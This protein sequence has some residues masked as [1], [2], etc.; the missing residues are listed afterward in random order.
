M[1]TLG[2]ARRVPGM[3]CPGPG[4]SSVLADGFTASS[5]RNAECRTT[6]GEAMDGE[7]GAVEH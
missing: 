7:P 3:C 1:P 4:G 6:R 5:S 2:G